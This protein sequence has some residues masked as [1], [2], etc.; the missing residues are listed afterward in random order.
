MRMTIERMRLENFKGC[1]QLEINFDA[2]RTEIRGAN[3][4]GKTTIADAFTW[5]LFNKNS[6]GDAPGSDNF[7]EKP[8]DENGNE[9]HNLDTTVELN[10]LLDGQR[11]DLKRTQSE[12]WVKKRG[13]ADATFQGNVSTYWINGVETKLSDFKQRIAAI[14]DEEVFRLVGSLSAFNAL[15]WKKRRA[16]LMTLAGEDVDGNL[17]ARAEYRPLADECG[18][19]NVTPDELRKVLAD[20]KKRLND[21]L[22]MLP[23]RIDEAKK[24]APDLTAQQIKDAEYIIKDSQEDIAR[25]DET[26]AAIKAGTS[27]GP[28]QQQKLAIDQEIVSIKHRLM[29]ELDA[30]RKTAT[31]EADAA[32]NQVRRLAVEIQQAKTY[33]A[34]YQAKAERAKKRCDDL[35]AK[36]IEARSKT[37]NDAETICPTCGQPMPDDMVQKAKVKF[38]ANRR[39]EM[40]DIKRDGIEAKQEA[41]KAQADYERQIAEQAELQS[42]LDEAQTAHEAAMQK[43]RELPGMPDFDSD[44]RLQELMAQREEFLKEGTEGN[45]KLEAFEHRKRDLQEIVSRNQAVLVQHEVAVENEKRIRGYEARQQEVGAQLTETEQLMILLEKFVQDRCGALEDSINSRFPTVR[46]KLFDRQINGGIIDTCMCMIPCDSGLVAYESANTAA[47]INADIEIVNVLSE[48]YDVEVPLFVD[49]AERV[50]SLAPTETQ[51]ITLAVSTD[52]ELT[53][54]GKG[55]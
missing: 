34:A 4:T 25:I 42:K 24:S 13:N 8:L 53:I 45:E 7:R 21:E 26:I 29:N 11:F 30:D 39:A 48:Y 3:G 15:E 17:L 44:S 5:L 14:A 36:F 28:T 41:E 20:Q 51:L 54:D 22:K 16:Q 19:R 35:R 27:A 50:V 9:L 38:E 32:G 40:D 33:A 10:C 46:W 23:I 6:H 43:V 1:R 52:N 2:K 37:F 49:N 12:N 55:A 18:Q 47:Q 31:A